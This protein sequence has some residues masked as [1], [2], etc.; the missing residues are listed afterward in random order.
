MARSRD[1]VFDELKQIIYLEVYYVDDLRQADARSIRDSLTEKT[2]FSD[3][4]AR[5]NF[6]DGVLD[7]MLDA[8][9]L[10]E[11]A[12]VEK[13]DTIGGLIDNLLKVSG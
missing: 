10:D 6:L 11:D 1:D 5:P 9:Y 3:L 7:K 13:A 12:V 8:Q 2:K 4:S